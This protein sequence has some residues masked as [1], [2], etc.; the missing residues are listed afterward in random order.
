MNDAQQ[1]E[2]AAAEALLTMSQ[3]CRH[4]KVAHSAFIDAKKERTQ[5]RPL[6]KAKLM[7]A[8]KELSE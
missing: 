1:I 3:V 8:I 7:R 6:T 5:M 2:Q 4:A